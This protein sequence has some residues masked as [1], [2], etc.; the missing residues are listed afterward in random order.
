FREAL[1]TPEEKVFVAPAPAAVIAMP[2]ATARYSLIRGFG[3]SRSTWTNIVFVALASVGGL[4]CAF[5]F[6]NGGELL[7]A[8]AAWP[9]E[10]LY[11]RPLSTDKI[12][13]GV[14]P[15]PV[16]QYSESSSS[17]ST[18]STSSKK[19]DA[20][21]SLQEAF[22]APGL[23]APATTIDTTTAPPP[24]VT[25]GGGGIILPPSPPPPSLLGDVNSVVSGGDALVQSLLDTVNQT[26]TSV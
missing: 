25:I 6:F 11:S 4:I 23:T 14:Q 17:K 9:S 3:L 7:R 2:N 16:D 19:S 21:D 24:I 8:A 1:S 22:L 18:T 20:P 15:N 10:F 12:D 26:V 13:V 5:Y